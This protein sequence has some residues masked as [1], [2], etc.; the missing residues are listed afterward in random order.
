MNIRGGAQV[1]GNFTGARKRGWVDLPIGALVE[2]SWLRHIGAMIGNS[3][4]VP[5]L[6]GPIPGRHAMLLPKQRKR[7]FV[8]I[9][10][11]RL[12]FSPSHRRRLL[13]LACLQTSHHPKAVINLQPPCRLLGFG[14]CGH[15]PVVKMG[16]PQ[17]WAVGRLSNFRFLDCLNVR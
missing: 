6:A 5:Q 1:E 10:A 15:P 13:S 2:P 16:D 12:Q 9:P 4:P 8:W 17:S 14:G 3:T 7:P 11:R